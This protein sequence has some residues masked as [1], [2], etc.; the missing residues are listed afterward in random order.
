ML[1]NGDKEMASWLA[2]KHLSENALLRFMDWEGNDLS[3]AWF[4]L[5]AESLKPSALFY[6]TSALWSSN[7]D[8]ASKLFL[9]LQ[10][11]YLVQL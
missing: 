4:A 9:L 3:S 7:S 1:I 8:S 2:S 5:V 11:S 6:D 10:K